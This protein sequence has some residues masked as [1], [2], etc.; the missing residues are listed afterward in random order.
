MHQ[1]QTYMNSTLNPTYTQIY[2]NIY[3]EYIFCRAYTKNT[4]TKK[5][6]FNTIHQFSHR[7]RMYTHHT[8]RMYLT[9]PTQNPPQTT[10][11]HPLD[12]FLKCL[13]Y[14]NNLTTQIARLTIQRIPKCIA[15]TNK[16]ESLGPGTYRKHLKNNSAHAT[17]IIW[18]HISFTIICVQLI[19]P[20]QLHSIPN[21]HSP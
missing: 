5:C 13:K 21:D 3:T 16:L 4:K 8:H 12:M 11:H 9:P 20:L 17:F 6:A 2:I 1:T 18:S 7:H 14:V 15:K 19:L 10:N